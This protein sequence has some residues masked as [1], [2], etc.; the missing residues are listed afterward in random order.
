MKNKKIV[1]YVIV[2]LLLLLVGYF[3]YSKVNKNDLYHYVNGEVYG[4]VDY[5]DDM[6]SFDL[7]LKYPV[8]DIE[9]D[10][11]E[12]INAD[13]KQRAIDL[14]QDYYKK[15]DNPSFD[16]NS[17]CP[18]VT[19]DSVKFELEHVEYYTYEFI[20]SDKYL[21]VIEWH[22]GATSCSGG[23]EWYNSLYV[24]NKENGKQ[25]SND[26]IISL[27]G[28]SESEIINKYRDKLSNYNDDDF[29]YEDEDINFMLYNYDFY[30]GETGDL[31][32]IHDSLAGNDN[33][34]VDVKKEIM[35]I[36]YLKKY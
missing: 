14:K 13:I 9:S 6:E 16:A 22:H 4:V 7:Q 36:N 32:M 17:A 20:E 26:E 19:I 30:I 28:Y 34:I 31:Y 11:V 12:K 33:T 24:I 8:I 18:I 2:V 29:G 3:V 25:L 15:L 35:G 5:G 1:Y 21:T 10:D 27:Y 23:W